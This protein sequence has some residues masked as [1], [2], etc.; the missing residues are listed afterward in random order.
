MMV[1]VVI[2][3]INLTDGLRGKFDKKVK[4]L[5]IQTKNL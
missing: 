4:N 1:G 3:L 5:F 2:G